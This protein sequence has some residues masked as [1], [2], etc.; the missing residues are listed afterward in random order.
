MFFDRQ[1]SAFARLEPE[2]ANTR[3]VIEWAVGHGQN[4]VVAELFAALEE[5]RSR[6]AI[7]ARLSVG[8]KR[9]LLP[10]TKSLWASL[11]EHSLRRPRS[12][13]SPET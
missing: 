9:L 8:S 3:A 13:R 7:N 5:V 12:P 4:A 2:H 11:S 1:E 6:K 10:A